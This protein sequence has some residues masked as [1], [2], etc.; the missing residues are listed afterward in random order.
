MLQTTVKQNE[1]LI[2][3]TKRECDQLQSDLNK[4]IQTRNTLENLC[5]EL[6]RQSKMMHV[7]IHQSTF[8]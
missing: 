3:N 2:S 4:S 6:Q 7:S 8:F 5:R 1:K